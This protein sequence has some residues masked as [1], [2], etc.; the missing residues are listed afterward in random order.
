MSARKITVQFA[1]VVVAVLGLSA[2][3]RTANADEQTRFTSVNGY[4]LA[5][6]EGWEQSSEEVVR[7]LSEAIASG[8]NA[9]KYDTALQ[10]KSA[11]GNT[12]VGVIVMPY[13]QFGV[14]GPLSETQ[15]QEFIKGM[16]GLDFNQLAK[17]NF[18]PEYSS[19]LNGAKISA[20]HWDA[21]KQRFTWSLEMEVAGSPNVKV[22]SA[23]YFGQDSVVQV[24][25]STLVDNWN[26]NWTV[27]GQLFESFK[28]ENGNALSQT[29]PRS[30]SSPNSFYIP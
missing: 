20:A 24:S 7:Q 16:T 26:E 3:I 2:S 10:P 30:F 28:F 29:R 25:F 18:K 5:V 12:M 4:S 13:A 17:E 22:T 6:P 8:P 9:P 27:C 11:Q 14:A 21:A 23:V 15:I 19:L 1:A